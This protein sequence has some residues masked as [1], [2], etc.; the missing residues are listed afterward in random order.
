MIYLE[1]V[2]T[3]WPVRHLGSSYPKEKGS[4]LRELG[5]VVG[6]RV[7]T[8]ETSVPLYYQNFHYDLS[9]EKLLNPISTRLGHFMALPGTPEGDLL[10]LPSSNLLR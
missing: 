2:I 3:R 9:S 6:D 5:V 10:G 8:T 4:N 1:Q 7:G